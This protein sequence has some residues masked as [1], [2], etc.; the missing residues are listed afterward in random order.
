MN[1]GLLLVGAGGHARS[2][3]EVIESAGLRIFG[4]IDR[5]ASM[6]GNSVLGYPILG[7]DADLL[8]LANVSDGVLIAVGQI[9]RPK[10]RVALH[11]RLVSSGV[12]PQS[13]S[14]STAMVSRHASIGWGSVVMHKAVVNAGASVGANC[15]INTGAIIEH[16]VR[17]GDHCHVAIGAVIGGDVEIGPRSFVGAGAIIS[18]G[19]SIGPDSIIGSGC[20]VLSNCPA[21][22]FIKRSA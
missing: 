16:D 10:M 21:E 5:D 22:T 7:C 9:G 8:K 15:I 3:I 20:I 6:I 13:V 2:C 1:N 11:E 12:M 4:L 18:H 19:L 14:A 17:I